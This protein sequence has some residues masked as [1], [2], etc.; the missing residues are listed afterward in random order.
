M[1]YPSDQGLL[2]TSPVPEITNDLSLYTVQV[3]S[4]PQ[5]PVA[6]ISNV[7]LSEAV[8]SA[9]TSSATIGKKPHSIA[10]TRLRE[11]VCRMNFMDFSPS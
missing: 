5:E 9:L 8:S 11:I 10:S 3:A 7:V 1:L 4:V 2:V 6:T